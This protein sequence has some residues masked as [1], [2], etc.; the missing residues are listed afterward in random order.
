MGFNNLAKRP[1]AEQLVRS[2][3]AL[4]RIGSPMCSAFS[5]KTLKVQ[6]INFCKMIQEDIEKVFSYGR[7]HL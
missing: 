1:E 6:G 3:K 4:L 7:P 2:K 5:Q